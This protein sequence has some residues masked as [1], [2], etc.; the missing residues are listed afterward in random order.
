[1]CWDPICTFA[2][3][4]AVLNI[5]CGYKLLFDGGFLVETQTDCSALFSYSLL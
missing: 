4:G 5:I 3:V 1:M 2:E